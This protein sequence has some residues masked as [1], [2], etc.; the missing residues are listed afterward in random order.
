M[1]ESST[2]QP[3]STQPSRSLLLGIATISAATLAVQI[4]QTRLFSVLLWHHLTYMVVTVTLLGFAAGGS[5]LAIFPRL[6]KLGGDARIACS[7]C[8][9]LFALTLIGSFVILT[10]NP[11]DTLDIEKDRIQYFYLFLHY[12]YLII[13]FVFSGLAIA[14]SL[15]A[16]RAAVHRTYLWNLM[17]SGIGTLLF[18]LL[19][20]DLGG[21][22]SLF[23]YASLGAAGGYLC[24]LSSKQGLAR[25]AR[26][27][28]ICGCLLWPVT[29]V[30]PE[31]RESL[32]PIEPAKSKAF[33][34]ASEIYPEITSLLQ[35]QD[36][37]FP[38]PDQN[39]SKTIWSPLCRI[40]TL[41]V[42][43]QP[44]HAKKD[45]ADPGSGPRSQIHVFQDGD[46]PTMIWS[47][48]LAEEHDYAAH[49]YGL[50]YQLVSAPKV[51]VIGPGG[52]N[53]VETA[54]HHGASSV[55]AVDIN[56]DILALVQDT[57]AEYAGNIYQ[58]PKVRVINAEGRSFLRRS[59]EKYD[60]LQMSGTDTYSAMASG[61]YIFSESYLYTEEAFEDFFEHMEDD[62]IIS[63]IRFRFEPPRETLKLVAT[64]ARVLRTIGIE[65]STK[66]IMVI[67]Q[68]DR[69][70][71]D[72]AKAL[73]TKHEKYLKQPLRYSV[74]LLRKTAFTPEDVK[75]IET[76]LVPMNTSP[77]V[78]HELYYA[79]GTRDDKDNEY[80]SLLRAMAKGQE[81]EQ[82][83]HRDYP[84][85]TIPATD[86]KP[87]FFN[88]YSWSDV[89]FTGSKSA[90]D[91]TALTGSEPI[92]LY[93][94][95]ALLLQTGIATLLLVILPLF[96][97][98]FTRKTGTESRVR[99]FGFFL[100]LGLAYLLVE[101]AT[102]QRFV[103]YL[104]HP[105][106]SLTV[107][108]AS[109][110]I[111]SGLG[112]AWA[113]KRNAGPRF[114]SIAA[115]FVV[116]LLLVHTL[117]LPGFLNAT[118]AAASGWRIL[119]AVLWIAPLAFAMGIPFP[120]GLKT[121]ATESDSMLPWA[122]GINGAASVLASILSIIIAMELGFTT[123]FLTA[124]A[125]YLFAAL[126]VP[127]QRMFSTHCT[128]S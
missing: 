97:L 108:L 43:V 120:T 22:G 82:R 113:G 1:S 95:A 4:L 14:I 5:L 99:V 105:T 128:D 37:D 62:G 12:A 80:D 59:D 2:K 74:T 17:G 16:Y 124:T 41:A 32:V 35:E 48:K 94:L 116:V 27:L 104:G 56:A 39:L 75:K 109:F 24:V 70:A 106:Y 20:R 50:G 103:L 77:A 53:D 23:F 52:G 13:P 71:L 3:S 121:V 54:L 89:K 91:Y 42:P 25:V 88:F 93:I 30:L 118:L 64:A 10:H 111:F 55:T 36:K 115:I 83:F 19:I 72:L 45:R 119:L 61:S 112:S 46:A 15:Q 96:R 102:I 40:D 66:H 86:D 117:I 47:K 98:G 8:C 60:L 58:H 100:F 125:L 68:E 26:L 122:F 63:I 57:F 73:K 69:Q 126:T 49:F 28:A 123:V 6:A 84:F 92:G 29:L 65:D 21:A 9:S 90:A 76:A 67:N 101:I 81:S 127:R 87:F 11:L 34:H 7:L 31:L 38:T 78:T 51:L 44:A 79:A 85:S 114:A 110:L 18:V 33:T 107:V